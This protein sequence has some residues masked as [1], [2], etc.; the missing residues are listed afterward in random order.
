[1][2]KGVERLW[3]LL[4]FRIWLALKRVSALSPTA[5]ELGEEPGI[6]WFWSV[7]V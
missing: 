3:I 5:T 1:M 7:K 6:V 4:Q 2:L